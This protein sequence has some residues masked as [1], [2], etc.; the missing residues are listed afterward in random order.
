[1][2]AL[3]DVQAA[4]AHYEKGTPARDNDEPGSQ[5]DQNIGRAIHKFRK[6]RRMIVDFA[7]PPE[8]FKDANELLVANG[9]DAVRQY[10]DSRVP[11][12]DIRFDVLGPDS[13]PAQPQAEIAPIEFESIYPF[14]ET[15]IPP[16]SL[17]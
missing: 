1:M 10:I 11:A 8:G 5:A 4:A 14:N 12:P 7:T 16:H 3:D 17:N 2:S 13:A 9:N 6:N 15:E